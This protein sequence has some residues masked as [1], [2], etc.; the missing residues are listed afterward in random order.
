MAGVES[1][2]QTVEK[3]EKWFS[4]YPTI[5][6]SDISGKMKKAD[7]EAEIDKFKNNETQ[8]LISTT[9]VEVG[10]NV[11]NATVMVLKNSERFGLAQAHQLRGRV[12]RGSDQGY[13]I[14]QT[15]VENEPK[16]EALIA[17]ADGFEIS[18]ADLRLRGSGDFL[19][20]KQSGQNSDVMLM[21]ANMPL[22]EKIEKTVDKIVNDETKCPIYKANLER[23]KNM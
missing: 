7:I 9:I 2:K 6:I 18:K 17:S 13:M 20:T 19:G 3:L 5:K 16:A 12:G 8:I 14:L 15:K 11:P 21:L 4:K 23:N 22:F 10:V 1:V